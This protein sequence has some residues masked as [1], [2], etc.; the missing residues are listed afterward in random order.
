MNFKYTIKNLHVKMSDLVMNRTITHSW[1]LGIR[2]SGLAGSRKFNLRRDLR[3]RKFTRKYTQVAKK[4]Q[5]IFE[6]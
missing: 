2:P 5:N 1:L 3:T 6:D 4:I